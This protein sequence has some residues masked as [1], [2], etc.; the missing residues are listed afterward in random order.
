MLTERTIGGLHDFLARFPPP[1]APDARI[2]DIGGG[3][4][5]WLERFRALGFSRLEGVDAS[6]DGF[7]A[8][9]A[10]FHQHD[11]I[12]KPMIFPHSGFSTVFLPSKSSSIWKTPA[13]SCGWQNVTSRQ[14]AFS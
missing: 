4:G 2:L 9:G 8:Q 6:A 12:A 5:A 14:A 10:L 1:L 13:T 11:L 7:N 3:T